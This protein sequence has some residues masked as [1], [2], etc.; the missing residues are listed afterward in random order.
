MTGSELS[1]IAVDGLRMRYGNRDVLQDVTFQIAQG[2]V[3]CLLGPNGAGKTTTIEILEGFRLRS[4]GH[5]MVL[6][7]DPAAVDE[8]WRAR[9]GIVLQS[10]RDHAKWR[11]RELIAH[12][13]SYYAPYSSERVRRPWDPDELVAA[14]GLTEQANQGRFAEST[15]DSTRF[16]FDLFRRYGDAVADLEVRRAS[17]EDTYLALVQQAE[18]GAV[19]AAGAFPEGAAQ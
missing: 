16:A 2:E 9:V 11:V 5:V 15:P 4:A 1:A 6:G 18:L 7:A 12:L 14:V 19:T 8:Q 10:W 17:L 13:G 3:V